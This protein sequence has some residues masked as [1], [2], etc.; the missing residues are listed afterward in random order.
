MKQAVTS[1]ITA[2]LRSRRNHAATHIAQQADSPSPQ[3]AVLTAPQFGSVCG[4]TDGSPKGS[5]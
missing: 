1:M 5:W 2:I 4:A 3:M